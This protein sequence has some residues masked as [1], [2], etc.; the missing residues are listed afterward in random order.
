MKLQTVVLLCGGQTTRLSPLLRGM[1]ICMLPVFNRPLI[2]HNIDYLIGKGFIKILVSAS[3]ND[4]QLAE[5]VTELGL[6]SSK[7][8]IECIQ[9]VNPRGTAGALG[10]LKALIGEESFVTL[11]GSNFLLDIDFADISADH[12]KRGSAITIGVK[13]R[14]W[15]SSEEGISVDEDGAVKG[16]SIIHSSRVKR[17]PYMATGVYV[18]HPVVFDFIKVNGF[19]DIKEQLIP[20]LMQQGL[21][22]HACEIEGN[23]RGISTLENYFDTHRECLLRGNMPLDGM[24][25]IADEVYV[26]ESVLISPKAYIIGPVFIGAN[27]EIADNAQ[28]IGP[29][30]IGENCIIAEGTMIRESVMWQ[31]C[32]MEGRSKLTHCIATAGLRVKQMALSDKILVENLRHSDLN[33]AAFSNVF[34]GMVETSKL[35]LGRLKYLIFLGTKRLIDIVM[36]SALLVLLSPLF[37]LI[38]AAIKFESSGPAIFRQVRCGKDGLDFEMLKFRS[39]EKDAD[40]KQ[41]GLFEKKSVDGPVF[42]LENDPRVTRVGTFLRK[43]SLDELPQLVNVLKGDMSLVGPRPLVMDEMKFSP[44]W[45]SI[46]LKVKPGITGMWQVEGRGGVSFHDWISYDVQYVKNQSLFLDFKILLKTLKLVRIATG[47]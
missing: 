43:S 10:D 26:G 23:Y 22:L 34:N 1:P 15:S 47:V 8:R 32:V 20:A 4:T 42:K 24:K 45:R 12:Y 44:S 2:G 33:L 28:I 13:K 21:P 25:E 36:S 16:F 6:R 38:A 41:Q 37:L 40:A 46:R 19:F 39:M 18:F 11:N 7:V 31:N 27:T 30:V 9:E 5:F 3:K 35:G 14:V 29:T 17:S